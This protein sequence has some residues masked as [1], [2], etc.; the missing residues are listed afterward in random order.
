MRKFFEDPD[1]GRDYTPELTRIRPGD[2]IGCGYEFATGSLFYTYN[3]NRLP[4]AFTG[5]Y[6]PRHNY[7]VFAAIG[8]SGICDLEVNFGGEF[9]RWQEGNEWAWRIEGHVGGNLVGGSGRG[10]DIDEELPS[11]SHS[12]VP[13]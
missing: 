7:D 1:G 9:F 3:G 5:I 11:Y 8:V 6:M 13:F 10:G 2:T 4:A 12:V